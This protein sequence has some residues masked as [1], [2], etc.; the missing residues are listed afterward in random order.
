MAARNCSLARVSTRAWVN[1]LMAWLVSVQ[2]GPAIGVLE[3]G[4]YLITDTSL[5]DITCSTLRKARY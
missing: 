2:T 4:Y 3:R 1:M 5:R